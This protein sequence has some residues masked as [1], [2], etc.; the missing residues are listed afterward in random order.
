M[1]SRSRSGPPDAARRPTT[2]PPAAAVEVPEGI[3]LIRD[4]KAL[5]RLLGEWAGEPLLAVDTEAASFHR[6]HDRVYLIQLSTRGETAVVDPLAVD[7]LGA[8]GERLADPAVEVVFHD[9]DYDLRLLDRHYGFRPTRLFD[10]RIAAQFLNEPGVGLAALLEKYA[11]VKLDKKY[12]RA[13]WS[14]RPLKREMIEYAAHDTAHLAG[15]RDLLRER[16]EAAGR[17]AWAE[18]EFGLLEELRWSP[19]EEGDLAFL[20]LKGAK[21]L[22]GRP[23]AIL[24]EVYDWREATAKR[25]DRASF[26]IIGNEALFALAKQP[27]ETV[28]ALAAMSGVGADLVNRRGKEL[29]AAVRRGVELPDDR[30]P[31]VP[32]GPRH[33]PDPA[34]EERLERLKSARN[35][36]ATKLELAPGVLCPN[37]TLEAIARAEP[38]SL[39]ALAQVEGVRKWQVGAVGKDL[40]AALPAPA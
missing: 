26:R 7:Q 4:R 15:L 40:L 30:I 23:L 32:R 3:R 39:E 12:Q 38:A 14:A 18:E 10:T 19:A 33:K 8:L 2:S 21:A 5:E 24:R 31:R 9:A 20:R 13:D 22:R 29:L 37:G 6:Y 17:L 34:Y 11:G 25:L 27:P 1:P 28:E 35:R 16:L 36:L